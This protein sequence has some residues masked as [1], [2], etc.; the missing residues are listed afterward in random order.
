MGFTTFG[1]AG[2]R[3]DVWEPDEDVYWGP[4]DTWLG[5]ERY[6][7]DRE[8]ENPLAA[9]QMGLIYVNPEGPNGDPDPLAAARD[10]RETFAPDGDE[11]RG[12]R[13]ADRRRPHLRQ[14]PRRGR[15]R[16]S[17]SAPS[18]RARRWSSRASAGRTAFGTGKGRD[19]ITSGLEVTWTPTPTAWDNSF[20]ENL[21]G[22]EWELTKSPAGANQWQPKDG[23]GAGTVP[24]PEDGSLSRAAD[25]AHHR[26]G[27][28]LRPGLRADLAALPR[29]PG[30]V[31]RRVRPGLVQA[32]P[33]RHGSDP[34][35]PRPAGAAGD[36]ALAGPASRRSTTSWSV[37]TTIAALKEQILASGL[38]VAQL[39]SDGLGVGVDVPRQRQAGRRQRRA[40]SGSSRRA[41]G[42]STIP[43]S[44]RSCCAPSRASRRPSTRPERRQAGLARR[45][46]R[47]GRLR[48]RRAG[49]RGRR[50]TT[51]TCPVHA[52]AHGRD[53]RSR[54]TSSRSPRSSRPPTGSATTSARGTG[55][56]PSTCWS[57]ARTCSTLSAPEMTVLVGGLRVLGANT[58]QSPL[59]VLTDRPGSL[60]N[61]FFVNLLDL[62][63]TWT[64]TAARRGD[65]RGPRRD[66]RRSAGPAAGSTSSSARTP[67]C[68]RSP[69]STPATTRRR[70][71]SATSSRRG[72]R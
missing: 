51:S 43:T 36:A 29:E 23:A 47:A 25:D 49:R 2:G 17:T 34:A 20:F 37:P 55:C 59:G 12:D 28:A 71:S 64:P 66:R 33:P 61:D 72:T 62:G 48:R 30:R 65:L 45:P 15:P 57:T 54:P 63:T 21:F 3:A 1:F 44:S 52:G 31:R 9:V 4:E 19:A 69:R 67:S 50:L 68:A 53:A 42:R 13:R 32:D 8:L 35:L 38:S 24:D 26:P 5:D 27:A 16:R 46:H 18:P 14:D 11:R 22:Y 39:V 56:R 6:T 58:E 7:G 41:A 70:S 60:T 40:A 10:I